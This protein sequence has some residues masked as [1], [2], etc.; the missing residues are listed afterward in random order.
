MRDEYENKAEWQRDFSVKKKA[1]E[2][3]RRKS[4]CAI[5]V[6]PMGDDSKLIRLPQQ[7]HTHTHTHKQA[8]LLLYTQAQDNKETPTWSTL[9]N[10]ITAQAS[11]KPLGKGSVV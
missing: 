2:R 5:S 4:R 1:R 7:T 9:A 11:V 6:T 8:H 10:Q 3:E